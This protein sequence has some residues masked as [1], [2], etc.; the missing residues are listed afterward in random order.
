M[1][2]CGPGTRYRGQCPREPPC[3]ESLQTPRWRETD[4]NLRFPAAKE[5]N[6][7]REAV[8]GATKV[9]LQAV[10]YLPGTNGSNPVPSTGESYELAGRDRYRFTARQQRGQ[11]PSPLAKGADQD[12]ASPHLALR[13][14]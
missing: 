13:A 11:Q 1:S 6:P 3:P 2:H 5:M 12:P 4:S 10:A 9:R 7:L 14:Q 8:T